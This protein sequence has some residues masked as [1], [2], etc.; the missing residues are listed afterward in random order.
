[1]ALGCQLSAPP[2][3]AKLVTAEDRAAARCQA[4]LLGSPGGLNYRPPITSP[5]NEINIV[6]EGVGDIVRKGYGP[7]LEELFRKYPDREINVT[8][9]DSSEF[10]ANNPAMIRKME[11]IKDFIV[12]KLG[13]RYLDK[14]R[15]NGRPEDLRAELEKLNADVAIIAT[16]DSTHVDIARTWVNLGAQVFV[17]KPFDSN[18]S[19]VEAFVAELEAEG[20][21]DQLWAFDHYLAGFMPT[22]EQIRQIITHL[23]GIRKLRFYLVEDHSGADI[24]YA[25]A[26][27]AGRDGAIEREGRNKALN[28]GTTLDLMPHAV[29]LKRFGDITSMQVS[30]IRAAKYRGVDGDPDAPA[31]IDGETYAHVDFTFNDLSGQRIEGEIIVGKGVGG[32]RGLGLGFEHGAAGLE[33]IG[34]NGNRVFADRHASPDGKYPPRTVFYDREGRETGFFL[35]TEKPYLRELEMILNGRYLQDR[36]AM[37]PVEGKQILEVIHNQILDPIHESMKNGH[38]LPTY[39]GGML[40][41][42]PSIPAEEIDKLTRKLTVH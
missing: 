23:G 24:S 30:E 20:R 1:M 13:A 37:S 31:E 2:S 10:W 17:E 8:F 18:L 3:W 12:N 32:V 35:N 16:P 38:A 15:F 29:M 33:L 40:N 34:N 36:L 27:A 42:R 28:A 19:K 6:I 21:H 14:S 9:L 22:D 39:P 4:N 41:G 5:L 7:A 26:A 25:S 11:T